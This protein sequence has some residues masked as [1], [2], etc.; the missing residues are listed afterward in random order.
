[1]KEMVDAY[2][3]WKYPTAAS[4]EGANASESCDQPLPR[5]DPNPEASSDPSGIPAPLGPSETSAPPG[6]PD[7]PALVDGSAATS[8]DNVNSPAPGP[9]Q[10]TEYDITIDEQSNK[11]GEQAFEVKNAFTAHML[12]TEPGVETDLWSLLW[13]DPPPDLL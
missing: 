6:P 2:L 8:S 7:A 4:D 5:A 3:T 11:P 12:G 9:E 1:M 10:H 13:R